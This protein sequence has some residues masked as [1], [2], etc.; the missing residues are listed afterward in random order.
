MTK[1]KKQLITNIILIGVLVL[2]LNPKWIPFISTETKS[3]LELSI[4]NI[5]YNTNI[6]GNFN[7]VSILTIIT[8]S[9]L[10]YY[11]FKLIKFVLGKLVVRSNRNKTVLGLL[12]SVINYAA[13]IIIL[14]WSLTILGVNLAGIFAS[15][16]IL[17]LIIGFGAQS[18]IEDIITGIFIIIEGQYNVN[19][20]IVLDDFR[21]FVRNIGVRTTTIEDAGGNLKI[22]NNS[23][24]RNLQNRSL[25]LSVAVC[26]VGISYSQELREVEKLL[27]D[28]LSLILDRN[29]DLFI[30]VPEYLG[31][32]SLGDSAIILR[33]IAHVEESKIYVAQRC[34]N[35]EIKLL[36][37]ANEI[38][39]PFKQV[40]IHNESK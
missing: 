26:D 38:E 6:G 1:N 12:M 13:I 23:D 28:E 14:I 35:R 16:G 33:I 8:V 22:I 29:K 19:D 15:L 18:L 10:V 34:L 36:F 30:T 32:Q 7:I 40:V 4:N 5:F 9:L 11:V 21:G 24:I 25:N 39:I 20:V 27:A 31:V 37:D 17:S 2:L 3:A